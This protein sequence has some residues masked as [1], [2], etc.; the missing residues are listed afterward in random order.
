MARWAAQEEDELLPVVGHKL[1]PCS[2][3]FEKLSCVYTG[4]AKTP[5]LAAF[6]VLCFV[7]LTKNSSVICCKVGNPLK[8][9]SMNFSVMRSD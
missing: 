2:D 6:C 5:N 1:L 3:G 7:F 9:Q 8:T 4:C